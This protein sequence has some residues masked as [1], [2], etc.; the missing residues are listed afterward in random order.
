MTI[1][2]TIFGTIFKIISSNTIAIWNRVKF[3]PLFMKMFP[4]CEQLPRV[5][6]LNLGTESVQFMNKSF[7]EPPIH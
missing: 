1:F 5:S 2:G 4:S 7:C 6:E 3:K